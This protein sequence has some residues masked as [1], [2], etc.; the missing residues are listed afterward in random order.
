MFGF[1]DGASWFILPDKSPMGSI[2]RGLRCG[3]VQCMTKFGFTD[4]P[5]M[6]KALGTSVSRIRSVLKSMEADETIVMMNSG[7]AFKPFLSDRRKWENLIDMDESMCEIAS[8]AER[9][10]RDCMRNEV[11]IPACPMLSEAAYPV[12]TSDA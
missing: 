3:I 4:I 8:S 9:L 2:D 5:D 6:S 11:G 12:R 7:N 10:R 1:G